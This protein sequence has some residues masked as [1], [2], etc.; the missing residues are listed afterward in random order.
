M[1]TILI[2]NQLEIQ[3]SLYKGRKVAGSKEHNSLVLHETGRLID[4]IGKFSR[5]N[6]LLLAWSYFYTHRHFNTHHP[7][8][9]TNYYP[10]QKENAQRK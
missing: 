8:K 5:Y 9:I 3:N 4:I 7:F 1:K 6:E 2:P 10:A